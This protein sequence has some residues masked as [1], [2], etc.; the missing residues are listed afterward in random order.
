MRAAVLGGVV[1]I[2]AAAYVAY[3]AQAAP[4]EVGQED[5]S[6]GLLDSIG[7]AADTMM[8]WVGMSAWTEDKI[9][10]QY[11]GA[12]REAEDRYLLPRNLLARLLWQESRY[13]AEAVSPVGAVGIAQFMPA[14]AAEFGVDPRNAFQSIDATGK[15]LA[16]LY[17]MTGSW[18]DALAAYNWGIGNL[19]R[20]GLAAAP[21]E[22]R[23]YYTQ[24]LA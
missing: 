1:L 2:G 5:Q 4:A 8:G 17:G 11:A 14:T 15:Y 24:I 16:R 9:P 6:G 18:R 19:R 20:K 12:I 10:A 23:N 22:T 13:R 7:Q 3:R 21:E